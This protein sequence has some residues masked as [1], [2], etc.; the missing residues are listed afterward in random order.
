M[1]HETV[2]NVGFWENASL[3]ITNLVPLPQLSP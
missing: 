2:T 3:V 1:P